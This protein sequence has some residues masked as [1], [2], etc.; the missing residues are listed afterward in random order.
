MDWGLIDE[1]TRVRLRARPCLLLRRAAA[2]GTGRRPG[3][4]DRDHPGGP[5]PDPRRDAQGPLPARPHRSRAA[6]PSRTTASPSRSRSSARATASF[7]PSDEILFFA[8]APRKRHSATETYVLTDR[9]KACP[10][11]RRRA[12]PSGIGRRGDGGPDR[13]ALERPDAMFDQLATVRQDVI[14]GPVPSP[15]FLA[16]ARARRAR[17]ARNDRRGSDPSS[18]SV[19]MILDPRPLKGLPGPDP[20]SSVRGALANGVAQK[21]VIN[22]NGTDLA[23]QTWDTP[24]QKS[25]VATIPPDVLR[26]ETVVRLTNLSDVTSYSEP[27]NE[28]SQR[29]PQRPPDR[30]R[31]DHLRRGRSSGRAS[32]ASR[33]VLRLAAARGRRSRAQLRIEQRQQ[34]GYLIV[35]PKVGQALADAAG[36]GARPTARSPSRSARSAAPYLPEPKSVQPLRPTQRAPRERG[37]RLRHRHDV[38]PQA[39]GRDARRAPPRRR[40][41]RRSSSRRASSTTPSRTARSTPPRSSGSWWPPR[42]TGPRS[43]ATW[44]SSATPTSTRTS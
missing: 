1:A 13:R 29:P 24:L 32:R 27:G 23:P 35:E 15:W 26:R 37:R 42:S 36:R 14:R 10:A 12:P 5:A 17:G 25:L 9:G 19:P 7:D 43:R 8:E 44:S 30:A 4:P 40:A 33:R 39:R 6:S 31:R 3:R 38:R 41:S 18:A 28:L 20:A 21:L 11:Q 2:P 22:V 34:E 16:L